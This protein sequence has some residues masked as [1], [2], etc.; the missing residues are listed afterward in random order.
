MFKVPT[1]LFTQ[2]ETILLKE[3]HRLVLGDW[4]T[5]RDG[6]EG[7]TEEQILDPRCAHC[8][9]GWLVALIP[10]AAKYERLRDDVDDYVNR[11]LMQA[12]RPKIPKA[13]YYSDTESVLKLVRGRAAEEKA[14][15]TDG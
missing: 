15:R 5:Y 1:D 13:I 14:K 4:H 10:G 3:P 7:V 2:L 6:E 11:I 8:L 9:A 12:G